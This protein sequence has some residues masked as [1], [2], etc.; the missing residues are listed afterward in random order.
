MPGVVPTGPLSVP[1]HTIKG[2]LVGLAPWQEWCGSVAEAEAQV[3]LIS[4]PAGAPRPHIIVD[5]D[6]SLGRTRD[7]QTVGPFVQAGGHLV[8][9]CDDAR[10]KDDADAETD[11]LNRVGAVL[12]ALE[13]L[14]PLG[15]A[16]IVLNGY[17]LANG[18]A[19]VSAQERDKHHRDMIEIMFGFDVTVHP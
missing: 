6:S 11:F 3:Y 18:P 7:G 13:L 8:Y 17:S 2:W 12:V 15:G 16:P 19:R 1:L 5:F 14:P 9:F 10:H 4:A